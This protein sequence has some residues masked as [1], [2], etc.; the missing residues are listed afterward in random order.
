MALQPPVPQ[1]I[2]AALT[3]ALVLFYN[4]SGSFRSWAWQL[5]LRALL[6]LH[7][8][9]FVGFYFLLLCRR[10]ELPRAFAVPAGLGDIFVAS[11]ALFLIALPR[12]DRRIYLAWNV[13]GLIDILFV[14]A[15]AARLGLRDPASMQ[16]L[17]RLPLSLLPTFLVP[18]IIVSHLFVFVRLR[19][20][21]PL[22]S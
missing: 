9:R 16:N 15:I 3:L 17:F 11:L 6:S 18:L 21:S 19:N 13:A 14:V 1:I 5:D 22:P 4:L 8:T 10:G 7:L 12:K 20:A 2:L